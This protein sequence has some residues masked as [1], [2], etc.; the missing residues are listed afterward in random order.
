MERNGNGNG[1]KV[2]RINES[3]CSKCGRG[4]WRWESKRTECLLCKPLSPRETQRVL[5]AA[6]CDRPA[7]LVAAQALRRSHPDHERSAEV[8]PV[9]N[10]PWKLLRLLFAAGPS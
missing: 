9:E 6:G 4:F 2:S 7:V 5:K 8:Q 1:R 10:Y 3:T